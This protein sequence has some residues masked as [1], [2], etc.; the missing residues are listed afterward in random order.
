MITH[1]HV[2]LEGGVESIKFSIAVRKYKSETEI[3]LVPKCSRWERGCAVLAKES[4]IRVLELLLC[5]MVGTM[6]PAQS[7]HHLASDPAGS[8][9][10]GE[11]F[12]VPCIGAVRDD[13]LAAQE[14]NEQRDLVCKK[15][16]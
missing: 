16:M 12:A 14:S 1:K 13:A 2:D 4:I 7:L 8:C 11:E 3:A 9:S 5:E 6:P 10:E 15:K